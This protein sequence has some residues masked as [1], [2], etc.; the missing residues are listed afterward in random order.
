MKTRHSL[1]RPRWNKLQ[2]EGTVDWRS[3]QKK[4]VCGRG[5][6][7][8]SWNNK[9]YGKRRHN[10]S[11]VHPSV[12]RR[13]RPSPIHTLYVKCFYRAF[14][15]YALQSRAY[16]EV[17]RDSTR[18]DTAQCSSIWCDSIRFHEIQCY[19]K[20]CYVIQQD[21]TRFVQ[22]R[23]ESTGFREIQQGVK[24][25]CHEWVSGLEGKGKIRRKKTTGSICWHNSAT[26]LPQD[27]IGNKSPSKI[28]ITRK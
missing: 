23:R 21:S 19:T 14:V 22:I 7:T 10:R 9:R 12:L 1:G 20:S 15:C 8:Y 11:T 6:A 25:Y 3:K 4:R 13:C 26:R 2:M 18:L 24:R 17:R 16:Y 28:I 5:T 27:T